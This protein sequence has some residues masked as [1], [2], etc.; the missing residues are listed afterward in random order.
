[1]KHWCIVF[2]AIVFFACSQEEEFV[3]YSVKVESLDKLPHSIVV[4]IEGYV[5]ES[6]SVELVDAETKDLIWFKDLKAG[7]GKKYLAEGFQPGEE[8]DYEVLVNGRIVKEGRV[9]LAQLSD[10]Y[11]EFMDV[12]I[13]GKPLFN[14]SYVL[15]NK[16]S[17]PSGVFLFNESGDVVWSRLSDNFVKMVKLTSR[18]TLLTLED[19]SGDKFG[20]GNLIYETTFTGD[21]LI[22]L[23]YGKGGFDRVAHH[24]VVLTPN[25][26]YAFITNVNV[27]NVVVDGIT[28]L[29]AFGEKVWEWDMAS[30]VL[31]VNE[32]EEFHQ[33]WGNSLEV[34]AEGNYIVS[35]RA[36]SQ[37]WSISPS[38]GNVDFK[39]GRK[40]NFG[41]S[42]EDVPLYQHH[43]QLSEARE[44]VLFDN[45]HRDER[46]YSRIVKYELNS[47]LGVAKIVDNITLPEAL[48]S[49]F[50]SAVQEFGE[51]YVVTSSLTKK[52]AFVNRAG[53]VNWSMEFGDRMFRAQMVDIKHY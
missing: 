14:G 33:P 20:N 51:G 25:G 23:Q 13:E 9:S 19:N 53:G 30:H 44:L 36:L 52:L 35:F 28:E 2:I 27:D 38:G 41:L 11:S 50:M 15:M 34:D 12:S 4:E 17:M 29:N 24:D 32:G 22:Q 7:E 48:F 16:M 31:P 42:E 43:A 1:M 6:V 8:F 37:V 3:G 18:G 10:E 21:T 45:G 49:P 46:P 26:T 39:F 40:C 5:G 47:E